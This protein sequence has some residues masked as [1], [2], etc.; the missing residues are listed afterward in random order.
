MAADPQRLQVRHCAGGVVLGVMARMRKWV[1][2]ACMRKWVGVRGVGGCC[3]ATIFSRNNAATI[4]PRCAQ[5]LTQLAAKMADARSQLLPKTTAQV[6]A[7]CVS[8]SGLGIHSQ[9]LDCFPMLCAHAHA[10]AGGVPRQ[11]GAGR[12]ARR[13]A[14][15]RAGRAAAGA[16]H[17]RVDQGRRC[18]GCVRLRAACCVVCR[19]QRLLNTLCVLA[20]KA[21]PL[22]SPHPRLPSSPPASDGPQLSNHTS[23]SPFPPYSAP[24]PC[25]ASAPHPCPTSHQWVTTSCC[26]PTTSWTRWQR[27]P[28]AR[29]R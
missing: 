11:R 22:P 7:V 21:S 28:P 18:R 26:C 10:R 24:Q 14:G 29:T 6:G 2:M 3:A 9:G 20:R 12:H 27:R 1:K 17:G 13:A 5:A 16:W 19:Q 25:P 15:A 23:N 4:F 8:A